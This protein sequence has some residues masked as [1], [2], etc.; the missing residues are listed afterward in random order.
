MSDTRVPVSAAVYD[1]LRAE[2]L[3][4]VLAPGDGIPSERT[5]SERFAVNR[6]AVREAVKRLQQAGL[7]QVSHGGATRVLDWRVHG[8]LE[9]LVDLPPDNLDVVRAG[10]E[11]RACIAADVAAR[12]ADRAD[13]EDRA[14][15]AVCAA[16]LREA[17]D[18]R[19]AD[20]DRDMRADHDTP[21]ADGDVVLLITYRALWD[22]LVDATGNIAYRLAYNS[23]LHGEDA[24]VAAAVTFL[25]DELHDADTAEALVAAV[26]DG[27]ADA[28]RAAATVL[29]DRTLRILSPTEVPSR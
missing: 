1:A 13:D 14:R 23:L 3:G 10:Y 25:R 28:A 17:R 11:L 15:L 18:L 2:I 27:D 24:I 22:V 8:G 20:E 7:V 29:T 21:A 9:L 4:G 19:D 5:L 26:L 16:A 6:H 12:A